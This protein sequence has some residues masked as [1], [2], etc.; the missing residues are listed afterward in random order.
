MI[1]NASKSVAKNRGSSEIQY[2][3]INDFIKDETYNSN[4]KT[5]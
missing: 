4:N 5:F 2:K 1:D 3:Y